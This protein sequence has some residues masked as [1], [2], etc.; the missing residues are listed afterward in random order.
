MSARGSKVVFVGNIPYDLTEEQ[1]TEIFQEVGPV[2]S[3]RLVFDKMTGKPRGFGFCEYYDPE[4]AASA[5]RNLNNYD[6]GGRQLRVDYAEF[7]STTGESVPSQESESR[8][9]PPVFQ[10]QQSTPSSIGSASTPTPMPTTASQSATD[11]ISQTLAAMNPT[12]LYELI[13]QMKSLVQSAPDQARNLL[14]Q[15]PQLSYAIFQ[16]M[17]MMNLV[18][19]SVLQRVLVSTQQPP[20]AAAVPPGYQGVDPAIG[21]YTPQPAPVAAAPPPASLLSGLPGAS[22][23]AGQDVEQHKALLMQV[24]S[25]TPQQI[26]MLPPE[27]RQMV[28]QLKAQ[29][30]AGQT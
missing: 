30:M 19:A 10:Q 25:L 17:L 7:D 14:T 3:F 24:L 15:N 26:D 4:T 2:Q 20:V 1:L 9:T 21:G 8:A 29:I 27:Q 6:V 5:V 28:M 13:S 22:A 12:Q 18:D 11:S 16:A 23:G